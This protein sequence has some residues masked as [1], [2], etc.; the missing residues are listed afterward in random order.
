MATLIRASW[1][2]IATT[3]AVSCLALASVN[4]PARFSDMGHVNAPMILGILGVVEVGLNALRIP[5]G[6]GGVQAAIDWLAEN[7]RE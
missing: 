5:H 6:M 3:N 4:C 7:V 1:W 2:T